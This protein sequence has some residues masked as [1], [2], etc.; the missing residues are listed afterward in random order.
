MIA[1]SHSSSGNWLR[2]NNPHLKTLEKGHQ[3]YWPPTLCISS[4]GVSSNSKSP[5]T[6]NGQFPKPLISRRSAVQLIGI[7]PLCFLSPNAVALARGVPRGSMPQKIDSFPKQWPYS[8]QDFDR[9]DTSPDTNFYSVPRIGGHHIDDDAVNAL[10]TYMD[11][12]VVQNQ[13][14]HDVLDLCASFESYLPKIWSGKRRV[15]GLGM[16]SEE[17]ARNQS[18]SEYVRVDLNA[19]IDRENAHILPYG[20]AEFDVVFC[21][22]S[23]DYLTH[24]R[25]VLRDAARVLRPK[26]ILSVA[27]S[28]RL[29]ATKAVAV[30]TGGSDQDHVDAVANYIHFAGGFADEIEVIDLSP[31]RRGAS[32]D[33]LYVVQARRI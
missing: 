33:P 7:L 12:L 24:P 9:V 26:G 10:E 3:R 27:F 21:A 17:M 6:G 20:D 1:F 5:D 28:D 30:W 4:S 13:N 29:F 16:N 31:R 8:P 25:E 18:L 22:L 11:Q 19:N 15:A 32:S 2:R 14:V 23:I